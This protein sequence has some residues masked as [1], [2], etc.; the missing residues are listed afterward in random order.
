MECDCY[1]LEVFLTFGFVRT[2]LFHTTLPD[3]SRQSD[4]RQIQQ[5]SLQYSSP[6][7]NSAAVF[8]WVYDL[9]VQLVA[10]VFVCAVGPQLG[11]NF[12]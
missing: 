5:Q 9:S 12:V 6:D 7:H 8:R 10:E 1:I 3:T 2:V 4:M 11:V